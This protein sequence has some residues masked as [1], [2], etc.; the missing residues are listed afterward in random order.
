MVPFSVILSDL[1]L[2]F[3]VAVYALNVL[4]AQLTRDP[5]AIGKFLLNSTF[6]L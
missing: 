1:N 4:C 5:F 6:S 2:D 3:K